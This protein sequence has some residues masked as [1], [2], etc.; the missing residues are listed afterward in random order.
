MVYWDHSWQCVH[1]FWY[2][3]YHTLLYGYLDHSWW[4]FH[5]YYGSQLVICFN[6]MTW[7]SGY[8][9]VQMILSDLIRWYMADIS[10]FDMMGWYS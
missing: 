1:T 5:G 10:C 2:V 8:G 4:Y 7:D 3:P 6:M 9:M